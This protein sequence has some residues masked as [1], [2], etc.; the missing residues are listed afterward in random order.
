MTPE[1]TKSEVTVPL[2]GV[3]AV[4]TLGL[5]TIFLGVLIWMIWSAGTWA[6]TNI[7]LPLYQKQSQF[8]DAASTMT[9]KMALTTDEISRTLK[10]HGEH[11][12]E[13][14]K[15][16]MLLQQMLTEN[17]EL[18]LKHSKDIEESHNAILGVLKDIEENTKH[19]SPDRNE[20]VN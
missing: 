11:S 10:A 19:T 3:D 9:T 14:L 15:V 20:S 12:V 4:K 2:W 8:I 13:A 18:L 7:L 17:S 6:G 16:N 5:P 1:K